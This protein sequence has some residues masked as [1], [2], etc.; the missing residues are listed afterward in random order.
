MTPERV[1]LP[2]TDLQYSLQLA[3]FVAIL[4]HNDR[5]FDWLENAIHGG[6]VNYPFLFARD[7][8]LS[9]LRRDRRFEPLMAQVKAVWV[10]M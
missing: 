6:V 3:E 9:N 1:R 8:F 7:P 5:A 4:G 10:R 2:R